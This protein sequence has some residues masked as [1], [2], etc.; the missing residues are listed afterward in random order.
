MR[1]EDEEDEGLERVVQRCDRP[2]LRPRPP[3]VAVDEVPDGMGVLEDA[4][5]V[6]EVV[7]LVRV[8]QGRVGE[9]PEREPRR[10]G[11]A[12][13][14]DRPGLQ[15]KMPPSTP[16]TAPLMKVARSEARNT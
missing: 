4:Q 14:G 3:L 12:E 6:G 2:M 1:T 16:T 13:N 15:S 7:V 9:Q 5:A 11:H 8:Q 10:E